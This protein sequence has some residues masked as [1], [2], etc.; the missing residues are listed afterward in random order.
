VTEASNAD[1]WPDM[2]ERLT[3]ELAE[4]NRQFEAEEAALSDRLFDLDDAAD[5]TVPDTRALE[6]IAA[7]LKAKSREA[8][9]VKAARDFEA[10]YV[11][12][13]AY[14]LTVEGPVVPCRV[15]GV[16][17]PVALPSLS[18]SDALTIQLTAARGDYERGAELKSRAGQVVPRGLVYLKG[19]VHLLR[20]RNYRWH[21]APGTSAESAGSA[22]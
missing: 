9:Q 18:P 5:D 16:S 10:H 12:E 11:G 2:V 4:L 22:G 19:G 20:H 7:K 13:L 8:E 21:P 1:P 6:E 14:L 17:V 15:I 3:A